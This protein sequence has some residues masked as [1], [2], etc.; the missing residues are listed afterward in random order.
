MYHRASEARENIYS[1]AG[2]LP[3][4]VNLMPVDLGGLVGR[5]PRFMY[6][7]APGL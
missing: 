1:S 7:W 3:P 5:G 2:G 4:Q 6:L